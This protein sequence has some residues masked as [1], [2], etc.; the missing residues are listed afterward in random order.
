M[1]GKTNPLFET[2]DYRYLEKYFHDEG[3]FL[4]QVQIKDF[5]GRGMTGETLSM[6]ASAARIEDAAPHPEK[7][8]QRRKAVYVEMKSPQRIDMS[9]ALELPGEAAPYEAVVKRAEILMSE[10]G[11]ELL[12]KKFGGVE[13]SFDN[14]E[15]PSAVYVKI[16]KGYN[17]HAK[18][19]FG[20]KN[21][22]ESAM[23][24]VV[25]IGNAVSGYLKTGEVPQSGIGKFLSEMFAANGKYAEEALA[26]GHFTGRMHGRYGGPGSP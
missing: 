2:E 24:D 23:K 14:A 13:I 20:L 11:Q 18:G 17:P 21:P 8:Y 19:P 9:L 4:P 12:G 16:S 10:R 5:V 7:A 25:E 15:E 3:G 1:V 22:K 26:H 6:L